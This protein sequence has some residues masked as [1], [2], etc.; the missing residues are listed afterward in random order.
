MKNKFTP[1]PG[2]DDYQIDACGKIRSIDRTVNHIDG[3][4][5]KVKGV[6]LSPSLSRGYHKV[7]IYRD[8]K[9]YDMLI[10]RLVYQT[11]IGELIPGMH[12]DH[13]DHNPLNNSISNLRQISVRANTSHK[14]KKYTSE[15]VGVSWQSRK[16]KWRADIQI[17]GRHINL[18]YGI[19]EHDAH[20][21]YVSKL[22]ELQGATI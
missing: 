3:R 16:K 13:I 5:R 20:L 8:G 19:S 17:N 7:R 22:K 21:K 2:F 18:G 11:F 14:K 4:V 15:Y 12:I 6:I 9:S 10:H 1:I